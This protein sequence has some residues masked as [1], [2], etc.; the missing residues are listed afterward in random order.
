MRRTA[1]ATGV[2]AVLLLLTACTDADPDDPADDL[3]IGISG[4][5]PGLALADGDGGY[6][7]LE[8]DLASYL[9]RGLGWDDDDITFEMVD[10]AERE[11]ALASGDVDMV[12]SGYAITAERDL[13]VDFAGPYFVAGQDL[14]VAEDARTT[15]PRDLDGSTVCGADGSAGLAQIGEE[16]SPGAVLRPVA[17]TGTCV[18]L[19]LSGQVDAVTADDVVLA[20]YAEEHPDELRVVG[21]PFT[22]H[23]YGVGL[24]EDSPDVGAVNT[25]I[26]SALA[27]GTWQA[28]VDRHLGR[29]GYTAPLPP[30]PGSLAF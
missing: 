9:A 11:T 24:P 5:D 15:G 2:A 14:L 21:S 23:Y 25:L 8:V 13:A 20:G 4:T 16:L 3:V 28:E 10:P 30:A 7:G 12:V 1:V 27:D 26:A 17:D 18:D 19:L 22:T 29:S 6:S